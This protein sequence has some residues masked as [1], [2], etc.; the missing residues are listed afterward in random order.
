MGEDKIA[1]LLL[2]TGV[3]KGHEGARMG[4]RVFKW[5]Q[6]DTKQG[7][8]ISYQCT[9]EDNTGGLWYPEH[10]EEDSILW[11][12]GMLLVFSIP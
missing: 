6:L 2:L 12:W 9:N 10:Q 4:E 1:I 8:R 11:G 5:Q 7:R 3:C